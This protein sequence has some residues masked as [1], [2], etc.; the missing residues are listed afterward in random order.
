MDTW[1]KQTVAGIEAMQVL[2]SMGSH[3][4]ADVASAIAGYPTFQ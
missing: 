2:N 4:E 3:L 1:V